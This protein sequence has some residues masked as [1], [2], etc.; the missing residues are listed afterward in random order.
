[1][2]GD[3]ENIV[4]IAGG[5]VQAKG[6]IEGSEQRQQMG[7][8]SWLGLPHKLGEGWRPGKG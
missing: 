3:E 8:V 2:G 4:K 6:D 5:N 7:H 1:M